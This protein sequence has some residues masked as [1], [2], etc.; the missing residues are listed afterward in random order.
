M[1]AA[2]GFMANVV[3]S[4]SHG[5]FEDLSWMTIDDENNRKMYQMVSDNA[6]AYEKQAND[7]LGK[8]HELKAWAKDSNYSLK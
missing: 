7:I 3:D 8:I 6:H 1:K 2:F 5:L 4:R